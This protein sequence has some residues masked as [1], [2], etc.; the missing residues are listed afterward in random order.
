MSAPPAGLDVRWIHG[1]PPGARETGP[2][3]Q[4]HTIN[5]RT[6]ILRQSKAV[7]YEAPFMYL[8]LGA[9]RA[10]LLDTGATE[11]PVRFPLRATVDGI[12]DDWLMR[13]PR[14]GEYELIVAHSHGH[15]DHVAGD[16]Q[17]AGR[18]STT[19]VGSSR[20]EVQAFFGLVSW[21]DR[22]ASFDL[23][24]RSITVIPCPG[25]HEASIA[26]HDAA[27]GLLLTGDTVYRG[28]LY[29]E[30]MPAFLDSL[31]RLVGFAESHPIGH[32][33]GGHIEM[34]DRP[35]RDYPMGAVFQLDE[36]RLEMSVDH[37]RAVRDAAAEVS[38][39]RGVH[40]FDDFIIFHGR[41]GLAI[42]RYIV[43]SIWASVCRA[44]V[45]RLRPAR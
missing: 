28:R 5:E 8:L 24:G 39:R 2:A 31:T 7:H 4:V 42:P 20:A 23:G 27:T 43:R 6:F 13:H 38:E 36:P 1:V 37:L 16:S 17:F 11:D 34:M 15:A 33:L 25:H 45:A 12:I 3:I 40:V 19:I 44:I 41:G 21:P 9:D 10:F 35:G 29:V 32:V 26:I 22:P 30:D 18:P 14:P